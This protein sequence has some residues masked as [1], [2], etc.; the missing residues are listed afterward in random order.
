MRRGLATSDTPVVYALGFLITLACIMGSGFML[1]FPATG[2]QLGGTTFATAHLHVLAVAALGM[3]FL[4][5]LHEVWSHLTGRTFREGPA[6]GAAM[7]IV[8]GTFLAFAPMFVAGAAGCSFRA[9]AYAPQFQVA[10]VLGCAGT[11]ILLAGLVLAVANL[12]AGARAG[13]WNL[14]RGT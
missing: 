13:T 1:A 3:A 11:T 9:N 6:K 7:V 12:A 5:G 8:V 4:G 2:A 10:H 14:E